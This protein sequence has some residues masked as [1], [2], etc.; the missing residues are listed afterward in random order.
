MPNCIIH[1]NSNDFDNNYENGTSNDNKN[2]DRNFMKNKG[3]I[4]DEF[5]KKRNA[6]NTNDK[7]EDGDVHIV[8]SINN[9]CSDGNNNEM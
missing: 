9:D 7:D 8:D 5:R 2:N 1:H 3:N 6:Y 4:A